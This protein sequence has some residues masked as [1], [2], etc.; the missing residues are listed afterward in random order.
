M[1]QEPNQI[2]SKREIQNC[3]QKSKRVGER[4]IDALL[5]KAI[6]NIIAHLLYSARRVIMKLG[7]PPDAHLRVRA[8]SKLA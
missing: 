3:F 2:C 5:T 7:L 6:T 4:L 8:K 1:S